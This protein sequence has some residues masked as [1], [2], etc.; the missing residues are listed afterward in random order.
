MNAAT[1]EQKKEKGPIA[2][3]AGRSVTANLMMAFLLVGGIL[4]GSQIKQELFPDFELDMVN[5]SV[6]Y[7]GAS[8]EEVER[9]ILLAVEEA[10]SD[11]EGIKE[12][13]SSAKEGSGSVTVEVIEG[14]DTQRL[15]QDIRNF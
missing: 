1:A 4:W 10:V 3:M 12:I 14:E 9:G 11:L 7:P 5:I 8:P 6:S 13:R 15:A 2:W